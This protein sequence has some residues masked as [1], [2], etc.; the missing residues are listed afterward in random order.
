[1]I[2]SSDVIHALCSVYT[3]WQVP[4]FTIKTWNL[5]GLQESNKRDNEPGRRGQQRGQGGSAAA[6]VRALGPGEP[7][8]NFPK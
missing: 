4:S 8:Q 2:A 5:V 6:A 1:M 3:I 7:A